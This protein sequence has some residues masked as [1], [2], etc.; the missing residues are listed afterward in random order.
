MLRSI[1]LP[2]LLVLLSVTFIPVTVLVV[3]Y[4]FSSSEQAE[5]G[6]LQGLWISARRRRGLLQQVRRS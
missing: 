1:G 5:S 4:F 2:E 6:R 3:V